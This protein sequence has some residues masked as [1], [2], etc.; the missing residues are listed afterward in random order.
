[1]IASLP[2]VSEVAA[3]ATPDPAITARLHALVIPSGPNVTAAGIA[4]RCRG[5]L[6]GYMIPDVRLLRALPRTSTGKIA[7]S[8]L[9]VL[10]AGHQDAQP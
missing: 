4:D 10:L 3:V 1:V 2:G 6:P 8:E 5:L 7:R 9:G